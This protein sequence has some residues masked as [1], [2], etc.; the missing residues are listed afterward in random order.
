MRDPSPPSYQFVC[1]TKIFSTRV[2][3]VTLS[4][5]SETTVNVYTVPTPASFFAFD[6]RMFVFGSR[7][8]IM[9]ILVN[10]VILLCKTYLCYSIYSV[11]SQ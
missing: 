3:R 2:P 6:L 1:E 11:Q 5:R 7:V 8:I 9:K 10:E 4:P